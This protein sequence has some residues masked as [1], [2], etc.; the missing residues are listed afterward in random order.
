MAILMT[1]LWA[2]PA[3]AGP[4]CVTVGGY[5][6]ALTEELLDD[7]IHYLNVKDYAALKQ[8]MD[9]GQA[10]TLKDGVPVYREGGGWTVTRIRL[11]GQTFSVWTVIEGV[12]CK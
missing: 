7:A 12:Q 9:S 5:P 4:P 6:F 10:G 11:P 1:A 3:P 8:L 2:A